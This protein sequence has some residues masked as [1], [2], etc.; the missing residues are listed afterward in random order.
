MSAGSMPRS[1]VDGSVKK[2]GIA[3][4][5]MCYPP[6]DQIKPGMRV[7]DN[8]LERSGYRL[9]TEA[10]WEFACRGGSNSSRWFGFDPERLD[11]HAWTARNSGYR[12]HPVATLLPNDYGLFDMLGNA[13]DF[14]HTRYETYPRLREQPMVDPGRKVPRDRRAGT[15][16]QSWRRRALSTARRAGRPTRFSRS[17]LCTRLPH[18]SHRANRA[19]RRRVQLAE[20]GTSAFT[21]EVRVLMTN[22]NSILDSTRRFI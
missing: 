12:L 11:E 2:E 16:V 4:S 15:G 20:L 21:S 17:Q 10:E 18:V 1:T 22:H 8:F 13:M 9:P 6:I 7:P 19:R 3:E 14:C 5:E